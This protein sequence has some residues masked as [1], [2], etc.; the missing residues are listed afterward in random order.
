MPRDTLTV[1]SLEKAFRVLEVFSKASG[2]LSPGELSMLTGLDKSA[3]QRFSHTLVKTG[4]LERNERTRRFRLGKKTLDLAFH[5]LRSSPL[6]ETATPALIELRR[7]CGERVSLSLRDDTSIIY[8]IR[9]QSKR[10]YFYSSLIGRRMPIFCTAG[11]R[12]ILSRLS[13]Q[14]AADIVSRSDLRPLTPKTVTDPAAILQM[15]EQARHDGF[16]VAIEES[17]VGELTLGVALVDVDGLPAAA[18]HIGASLSEWNP[19][20]FARKMA[21]LAMET[22][23]NLSHARLPRASEARNRAN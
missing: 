10:E 22:A 19:E 20:A 11:G 17:S 15:V 1:S 2:D 6:V 9:Q 13:P 3:V 14:H 23:R 21:P 5:F 7:A 8:V 12:A 18:I 16:A 4:Y